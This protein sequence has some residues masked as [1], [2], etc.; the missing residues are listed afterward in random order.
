MNIATYARRNLFR[1]KG[2]TILTVLAVAVVVLIFCLIRTVVV[3][4]NAGAEEAAKD[5]L[6]TI[7]KTSLTMQLPQRYISEIRDANKIKGIAASTWANWFGAKDPR[8]RAQFFAAFAVDHNSWFDV[9]DEMQVDPKQLETWKATRDGVIL[10]DVLAKTLEVEVGND[11][12]VTSDIYPGDWKFKVVGIYTALRKTVDRNTMIL[13]WDFLNDDQRSVE[14][15]SR[16]KIGWMVSRIDDPTKS[17]EISRAIDQAFDERDDQTKTMSER[18][19]QLSFLGGFSAILNGLDF[20]SIV[21]LFIMTLIL[22]NTMA[23]SVRERSH[24]Y[25][26]LRA[27]GFS[28]R[29]VLGFILGESALVAIVGGICGVLLTLLLINATVGPLLEQNMPAF[30]P[31]FRTSPNTLLTALGLTAVLG[32]VAALLPGY[33]ASRRGVTDALRRID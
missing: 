21:I 27:I 32:V 31:Y 23:M 1:R 18:A 24:E 5:R 22:A 3:A 30:F 29:Y 2:R 6:V 33:R 8:E 19:F 16:D 4:W 15:R 11:V 14:L 12:V 13:R 25:G 9:S 20:V 17:A 28:P 10:G 26:V 7:H